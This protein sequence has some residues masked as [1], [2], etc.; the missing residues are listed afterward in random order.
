MITEQDLKLEVLQNK[1]VIHNLGDRL[2]IVLHLM[3]II[4]DKTNINLDKELRLLNGEDKISIETICD[5]R[6]EHKLHKTRKTT[7]ADRYNITLYQLDDILDL[8]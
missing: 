7:L 6:A 5:I 4:G 8:A 2:N 1:M 3:Q